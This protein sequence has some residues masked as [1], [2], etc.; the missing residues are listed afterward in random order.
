L[1][2]SSDFSLNFLVFAL[3]LR[4]AQKS[5]SKVQN[6]ENENKGEVICV[7]MSVD[8]FVNE[9]RKVILETPTLQP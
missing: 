6:K 9:M 8:D 4:L 2:F 5:L 3:Y 1:V 7:T